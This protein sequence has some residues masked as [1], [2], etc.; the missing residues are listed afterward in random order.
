MDSEL[1]L[2][3]AGERL[4]PDRRWALGSGERCAGLGAAWIENA[5]HGGAGHREGLG[6][7]ALGSKVLGS[8][9]LVSE[10]LGEETLG[11]AERR[12]SHG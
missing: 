6:C 9:L 1:L 4:W 10:A 3:D 11:W 12:W 7:E 2:E 5:G 8:E